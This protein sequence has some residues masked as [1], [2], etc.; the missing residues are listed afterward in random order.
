MDRQILVDKHK[1]ISS[2]IG[3]EAL[4]KKLN[5]FY[6]RLLKKNELQQENLTRS[7]KEQVF[8][9]QVINDLNYVLKKQYT[10]LPE[11]SSMI[12]K[13]YRVGFSFENFKSVHRGQN[14]RWSGTDQKIYLRP[15]TL[16][17]AKK[18]DSYLQNSR[19]Y[20]TAT[21]TE[22]KKWNEY[23]SFSELC[24]AIHKMDEESYYKFEIPENLRELQSRYIMTR[25]KGAKAV[26][27]CEIIYNKTKEEANEKNG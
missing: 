10:L 27:E 19:T 13:L 23:N 14:K 24:T 17:Q 20:N 9:D 4:Q 18:F 12:T 15:S 21:K 8:C 5:S 7:K 22:K 2:Q 16:Y 6:D 26:Q 25:L 3:K 1:K 11:I